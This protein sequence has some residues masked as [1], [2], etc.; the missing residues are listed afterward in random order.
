MP[1]ISLD[2]AEGE[3]RSEIVSV[4]VSFDDE[5]ASCTRSDFKFIEA[6]GK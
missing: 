4:I 1:D 3:I 6:I 5:I 2:A